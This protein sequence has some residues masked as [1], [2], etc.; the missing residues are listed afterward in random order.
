MRLIVSQCGQTMWGA[1]D[2]QVVLGTRRPIP[3]MTTNTALYQIAKD[4]SG[5]IQDYV[6]SFPA[7]TESDHQEVMKYHA[8]GTL[9]ALHTL[10][11]HFTVCDH[12]FSSLAG[13]TLAEPAVRAQRDLTRPCDHA[14]RG[15]ERQ[16]PLVTTRRRFTTA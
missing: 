13:P 5:F 11:Q 8:R 3:I 16:S 2:I 12:W 4:N 10:A 6:N 9:P 15:D 1:S 14:R 7:S